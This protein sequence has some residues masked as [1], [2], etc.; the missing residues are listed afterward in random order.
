MIEAGIVMGEI[1]NIIFQEIDEQ[2]F[3]VLGTIP[4][5]VF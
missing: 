5:T 2:A 1:F 3:S 4:G